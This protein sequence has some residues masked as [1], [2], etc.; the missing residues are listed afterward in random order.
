MPINLHQRLSEFSYGYGVT[1]DVENLVR[2]RGLRATPFLP[3]LVQEA[4]LGF[5]VAF[6]LPGF[7]ILLQFKLGEEIRRF[8]AG[9]V[10]A[11]APQP[12]HRP[13]W[14]YKIDT[15]EDQFINLLRWETAGAGVYYAA[16]RF[17]AWS[18]FDRHFQAGTVLSSSLLTTPL[19]MHGILGQQ[20]HNPGMHHIL[21]DRYHSHICSEP[22]P[23]EEVSKESLGLRAEE[24]VKQDPRPLGERLKGILRRSRDG[25]VGLG[26]TRVED[27]RRRAKR[28]SDADAAIFAIEAWT[29]GAQP[30]FVTQ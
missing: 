4:S 21:Y 5:D 7:P 11:A 30:I 14:R 24:K 15:S 22:T 9:A 23:I 12:L 1:R 3:S 27:I 10:V 29:R 17:S 19:A 26:R 20:G 6:D 8:R 2:A 18:T 13:Y 25:E 16:P 28:E